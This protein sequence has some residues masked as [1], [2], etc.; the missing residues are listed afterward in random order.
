MMIYRFLEK[1]Y[2]FENDEKDY[3]IIIKLIQIIQT[4]DHIVF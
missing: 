2:K 4:K 1:T 3:Q